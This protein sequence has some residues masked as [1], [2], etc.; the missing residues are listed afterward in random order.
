MVEL[1]LEY[2]A[3]ASSCTPGGK[4]P[5]MYAAMFERTE[6]LQRLLQVGADPTV[7]DAEGNTALKLAMAMGAAD[8]ARL[9]GGQ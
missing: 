3:D 4:T 5:L 1:L 8:A 2:G 6:I 7:T 9:L